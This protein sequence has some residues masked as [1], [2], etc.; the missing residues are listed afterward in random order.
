MAE[1]LPGQPTRR[2]CSPGISGKRNYERSSI[3]PPHLPDRSGAGAFLSRARR[4]R[5]KAADIRLSDQRRW[6]RSAA[7]TSPVVRITALAFR[8]RLA[9]RG[10]LVGAVSG[11]GVVAG[12][13]AASGK[14][15]LP[16]SEL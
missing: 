13:A 16:F 12:L 7:S 10:G 4:G 9:G 6:M 15:G 14:V 11:A 2:R 8:V 3:A 1:L 5:S